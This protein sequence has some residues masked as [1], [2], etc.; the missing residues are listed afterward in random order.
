VSRTKFFGVIG[1]MA[2]L[3]GLA[4]STAL[5][6]DGSSDEASASAAI[7]VMEERPG[8]IEPAMDQS[9]DAAAKCCWMFMGGQWVCVSC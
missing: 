2:L 8:L 4:F 6:I 7:K 9:E 5:G 1:L 3:P